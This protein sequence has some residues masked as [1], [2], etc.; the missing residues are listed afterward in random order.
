[1]R[2]ISPAAAA[3]TVELLVDRL[4]AGLWGVYIGA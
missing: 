4:R 2:L 1:M 3:M